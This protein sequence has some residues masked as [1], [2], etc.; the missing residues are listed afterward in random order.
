MAT[1]SE[2]VWDL[3]PH[4]HAK[5]EILQRYL[6]AWFPILN[7]YNQRI[8][9]IDGFCG[10][11][12]YKGGEAGSPV[13]ALKAAA[14]HRSALA[15]EL[16][17]W[18][19]DEREDRIDHLRTELAAM[20]LPGHFKVHAECGRFDEK[21]HKVLAGLDAKGRS[22]APTFAFVDPFGFSGIPF[23]LIRDLLGRRQCEAFIT[24]MVD[25]INRWLTHP[26][27]KVLGLIA[28][29]FGTDKTREIARGDGERIGLLGILYSR[30]V[31][32]GPVLAQ[33][34]RLFIE[35]ETPFL[36]RHMTRALK[37]AEA[38]GTLAVEPLK[39]DGK[40]R[41][42]RTFPDDARMTFLGRKGER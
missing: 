13:V 2:T 38:A 4:I 34:V 7:K 36:K 25:S 10:P 17:F 22:L 27:E 30:F 35:N 15:G 11:G 14:N 19:I 18:F 42:A 24:F 32:Q 21:L 41:V 6:E 29:T 33:T 31:D 23:S 5:H 28:E 40:K 9:Y 26:N 8:I 3:E 16:V 20:T 1:P 37:R 12:R 39:V